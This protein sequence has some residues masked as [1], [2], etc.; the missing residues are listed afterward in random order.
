MPRGEVLREDERVEGSRKRRTLP[1]IA[2]PARSDGARPC[3]I[4]QTNS[5]VAEVERLISG[6]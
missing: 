2:R 3:E 5:L 1:S 4:K 6:C